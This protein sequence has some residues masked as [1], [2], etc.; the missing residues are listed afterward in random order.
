MIT[1]V[2][3]HVAFYIR[4]AEPFCQFQLP[5]SNIDTGSIWTYQ[6]VAPVQHAEVIAKV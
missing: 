4:R 6:D 2:E 1:L 5:F 3:L